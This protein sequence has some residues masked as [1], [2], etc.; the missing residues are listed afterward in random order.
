MASITSIQVG[1]ITRYP[2]RYAGRVVSGFG[3]LKAAVV[4]C[5]T[6]G[7]V[8]SDLAGTEN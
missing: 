4:Y 1:N 7:I 5:E 3:S 6:I 8:V 2:V